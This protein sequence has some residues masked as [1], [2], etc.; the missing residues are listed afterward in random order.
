MKI[1]HFKKYVKK[2]FTQNF[3]DIMDSVGFWNQIY[4]LEYSSL[5]SNI[6]YSNKHFFF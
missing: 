6:I 4:S 5:V 1:S 2:D 3:K